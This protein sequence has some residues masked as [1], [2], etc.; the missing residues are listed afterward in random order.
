MEKFTFKEYENGVRFLHIYLPYWTATAV[1]ISVAVGGAH[2]LPNEYGLS[3]FVE[4]MLLKGTTKHT[5]EEIDKQLRAL[6]AYKNGVTSLDSTKYYYKCIT[7][8]FEKLLQIASESF[9]DVALNENT[10]ENERAVIIEELLKRNT[11]IYDVEDVIFQKDDRR[12]ERVLGPLNNLKNFKIQDVKSFIDKHYH[13]KNLVI[14]IIGDIP[15]EDSEKLVD[16]YFVKRIKAGN[17]GN[18]L[19]EPWIIKKPNMISMPSNTPTTDFKIIF[20]GSHKS[21]IKYDAVVVVLKNLFNGMGGRLLKKLRDENG[22]VYETNL[23]VGSN[24]YKTA[25]SEISL[26]AS[27]QNVENCI[28]AVAELV[29]DLRTVHVGDDEL[30]E[31][32]A[33]NLYLKEPMIPT[34]EL[35]N[36]FCGRIITGLPVFSNAEFYETIQKVTAEDIYNFIHQSWTPNNL[37]MLSYGAIQN[38]NMFELFKSKIISS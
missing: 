32:K 3:H 8:N 24:Y 30:E 1:S 36:Y 33:K 6:G 28:L 26:K 15:F 31:A 25:W 22:L 27:T 14:C 17:T 37:Y 10:F 13:S 20:R 16:T 4:H 18:V 29:N 11:N 34:V 21:T 7:T 35:S 23:F 19:V 38:K 9:F 12:G 2:E 5:K